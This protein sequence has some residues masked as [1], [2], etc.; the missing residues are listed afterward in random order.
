M[1]FAFS[2]ERSGGFRGLVLGQVS[3]IA[4]KKFLLLSVCFLLI[5][6]LL[7]LFLPLRSFWRKLE[8]AL[9][10]S[11][12]VCNSF[13]PSAACVVNDRNLLGTKKVLD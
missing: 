7:F 9:S 10:E 12:R 2:R 3:A 6:E 5:S 1:S 8:K 11:L 13:L 4:F